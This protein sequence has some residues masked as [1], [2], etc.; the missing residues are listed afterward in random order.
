MRNYRDGYRGP[1]IIGCV[2]LLG[3]SRNLAEGWG[4]DN[5][6]LPKILDLKDSF[7]KYKANPGRMAIDGRLLD[8]SVAMHTVSDSFIITCQIPIQ[9]DGLVL[10]AALGN[11][12]MGVD[13]VQNFAVRNGFA[14]RGGVELGELF[15]RGQEVIGPAFGTAYE[16]ESTV[17][18]GARTILGPALMREIG[19]LY[20]HRWSMTRGSYCRTSDDLMAVRDPTPDLEQMHQLQARAPS[21][22]TAAK[23]DHFFEVQKPSDYLAARHEWLEVA[24]STEQK[25]RLARKGPV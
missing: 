2:D 20:D 22:R 9:N 13:E 24:D 12:C 4:T 21:A 14:V 25:L 6:V 5:D 15:I 11:V 7:N 3:F 10:M 16:L 18:I 1:A 19:R 23:Y 8:F 17:A